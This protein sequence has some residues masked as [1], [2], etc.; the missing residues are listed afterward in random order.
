M[1]VDAFCCISYTPVN[2]ITFHNGTKTGSQWELWVDDFK[3][4]KNYWKQQNIYITIHEYT[5]IA[6]Q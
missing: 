4:L 6:Y 1:H 2:Q 3:D 5:D